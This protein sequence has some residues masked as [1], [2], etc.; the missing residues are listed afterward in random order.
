MPNLKD[1]F[2]FLSFSEICDSFQTD[3]FLFKVQTPP[4]QWCQSF[5]HFSWLFPVSCSVVWPWDK[6]GRLH[7]KA[8]LPDNAEFLKSFRYFTSCLNLADRLQKT[9]GKKTPPESV[10]FKELIFFTWLYL[11][12]VTFLGQTQ[13]RTTLGSFSDQ[14]FRFAF[15]LRVLCETSEKKSKLW[16]GNHGHFLPSNS[17]F[18]P[19]PPLI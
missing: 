14:R 10:W 5:P 1:L 19:Q 15:S 17:I 11:W 13:T 12:R 3:S 18:N 2:I 16:S 7:E 8:A 4:I 9:V 6:P